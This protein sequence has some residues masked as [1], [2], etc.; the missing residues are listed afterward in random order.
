MANLVV[1]WVNEVGLSRVVKSPETDLANG[2]LLGELLS[3]LKIIDAE[4]F[5]AFSDST[6]EEDKVGHA[7]PP[8][9]VSLAAAAL[10][11]PASEG[12]P[13]WALGPRLWLK[14][15][16]VLDVLQLRNFAMAF[17]TLK[18]LRIKFDERQ[19]AR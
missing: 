15:R 8:I 5:K 1:K 10:P 18:L 17:K 14:S 3:K 11:L 16:R 19:V 7:F 12:R 2:Y 13:V 6:A 9:E 4:T